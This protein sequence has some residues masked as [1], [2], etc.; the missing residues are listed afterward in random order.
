MKSK[1]LLQLDP[2]P[3]PSV[4]DAVVAV[5]SG[6]DHL[7]RH[8]GVSPA[9]VTPLVHGLLFTRGVDD[10]KS[11]ALFIGGSDVAAGEGLM[12]AAKAAFFGP[13][14]V[15]VLF[16]AN[17]CNTT[18]AAAVLALLEGL[19]R[20]R[21]GAERAKVV[22]LAATGAV[23]QR[24]AR[25]LLG[26]PD[27]IQVH[28]GSRRLDRAQAVASV[29]KLA[30]ERTA[31]PFAAST[32]EELGQ[33]LEGAD[34]V[35]AAGAA[36]VALLP[37]SHWASVKVFVDLNAVPPLGIEGVDA[38]DR[39]KERDGA[40]CWGALGVGATKMKIHKRAIQS[41]FEG[42][43]QTIDAEECLEIGRQLT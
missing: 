15:S 2:D 36:G 25:L 17:G 38:G 39:G 13:F 10:L 22:I 8:G 31:I 26:L 19:K 11:S 6:V 33:A 12:Q 20:T 32:N 34:A 9:D 3:Q 28:I 18:S 4:F 35:I 40:L 41:L 30:T 7:L 1:L 24:V 23:G 14:R 27:A 5:D 43:H 37:R 42:N 21:S 29:L 16:D